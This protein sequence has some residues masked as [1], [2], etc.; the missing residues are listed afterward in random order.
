MSDAN[1]LAYPQN[2]GFGVQVGYV[3]SL[4]VKSPSPPLLYPGSLNFY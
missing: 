2:E 4:V 1:A 3:V